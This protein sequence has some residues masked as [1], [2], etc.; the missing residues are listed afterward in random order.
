MGR[1]DSDNEAT[2]GGV[3]VDVDTSDGAPAD[4][5]RQGTA[6]DSESMIAVASALVTVLPVFLAVCFANA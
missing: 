2:G 1:D 3:G 4:E 5:G 6:P